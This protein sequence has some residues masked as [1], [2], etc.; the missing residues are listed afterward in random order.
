[1]RV[2]D[3][4][5]EQGLGLTGLDYHWC[6]RFNK[7]HSGNQIIPVAKLSK[8]LEIHFGIESSTLLEFSLHYNL[9]F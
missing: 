8:I 4:S 5:L 2:G 7:F 9:V 3:L 1:M 6:I